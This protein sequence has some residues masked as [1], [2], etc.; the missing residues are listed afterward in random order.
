MPPSKQQQVE[1]D[2]THLLS[3]LDTL[4][5]RL[6]DERGHAR[7]TFAVPMF[8]QIGTH[9]RD[10]CAARK[11]DA[12]DSNPIFGLADKIERMQRSAQQYLDRVNRISSSVVIAAFSDTKSADP[13]GLRKSFRQIGDSVV[14]I[15]ED[16]VAVA[17]SFLGNADAAEIWK[18]TLMAFHGD[19]RKVV[20]AIDPGSD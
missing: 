2:L 1:N 17:T 7:P 18:E 6:W 13:Q 9:M 3:T 8:I 16:F 20:H 19:L 4:R 11:G 14:E 15:A 5:A 12:A 10:F